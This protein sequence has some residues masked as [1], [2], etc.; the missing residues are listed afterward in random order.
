VPQQR[1]YYQ[2]LGVPRGASD[3]EIKRAYRKLARELHP[4]VNKAP[5]AAERFNA[6]N[7]AYEVLSDAEKRQ[8]YDRFGT[9]DPG[10]F[11]GGGGGRPGGTYS[12]TN[13]GGSGGGGAA[14]FD[15]GDLGAMFE[16][17][18]GVRGG[19]PGGGFGGAAGGGQG[20]RGR[21]RGGT[22]A[23]VRGEDRQTSVTVSFMT[24][25]LGGTETV[26]LDGKR[27]ELS[28]PAGVEDGTKLRVKGEGR[29][30]RGGA[31]AGDLIVAV[32]VGAHPHFTRDG[33]DV[34][35]EVPITIAEATL[36]VEV[37]VPMLKGSATLTIPPGSVSG[38]RL[39]LRG[40]GIAR[41]E[42]KSGDFYAVVK[43]VPPAKPD[44]AVREALE[45]LRPRLGDPR[46]GP[47]WK[48]G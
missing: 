45:R 27:I 17:I 48:G 7:E 38:K 21:A 4:D 37:D 20:A 42:G 43:I 44:E 22:R 47:P 36:G 2:T 39:R 46:S 29:P 32:R 9:A 40:K 3:D 11:A 34:S 41:K 26:H 1:D 35:I 15:A 14:G 13:V 28:I 16:E 19:S 10:P 6:V 5:D 33:L 8:N 24:A 12:W 30:G 18:F 25:A 23:G 31:P